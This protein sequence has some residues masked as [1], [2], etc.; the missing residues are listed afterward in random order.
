M[1]FAFDNYKKKCDTLTTEQLHKE[2]E[3]YTRQLAGGATSTATSVL[4]SP[5]TGG[6]SLVGLG[7]SAPRIH[8]ARKKRGIIQ[9]GLEA[10]GET[11]NT[12]KRDVIAPMAIA[13]TLGTITLG[14]AG[15]VAD[16]ATGAAVGHGVEYAASHAA[17]D[18]A[19]AIAEHKHDEHSKKKTDQKLKIQYQRFQQQYIQEQQTMHG[20]PPQE[21]GYQTPMQQ[22]L[23]DFK[24]PLSQSQPTTPMQ[25]PP[26]QGLPY[27]ELRPQA[28]G[29]GQ[30]S[31]YV[32]I[33]AAQNSGAYQPAS[34]GSKYS[35]PSALA[36]EVYPLLQ[37]PGPTTTWPTDQ[38]THLADINTTGTSPSQVSRSSLH[39]DSPSPIIPVPVGAIPA[40]EA[41][42]S[43]PLTMEQE[44][45]LL[46]A[47]IL[48][49]ELEKR[50]EDETELPTTGFSQPEH[51]S[52]VTV[53][54]PMYAVQYYPPPP[55][56]LASR[57]M[58]QVISPGDECPPY[59]PLQSPPTEIYQVPP[60][61]P[62][63]PV[64]YQQNNN[65]LS[66]H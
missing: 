21:N 29:Q 30:K 37:R 25:Y 44:I 46:K 62:W 8:N 65:M 28:Q 58:S 38:K 51:P 12:R 32:P 52:T 49:M 11:H 9:A 15:P 48:Q 50:G 23:P 40:V 24:P 57:P 43:V 66:R 33:I 34:Q 13:G 53:S 64:P 54:G 45:V 4:F 41:E 60:P 59:Q 10:R 19:G 61:P 22:P 63:H 1:P 47:R 35:Q 36:S 55:S 18:G 16:A 26:Q 42:V 3:N 27:N 39:L 14:L 31:H 5:L 6:I 7:L 17:L 56:S 20:I 2:W